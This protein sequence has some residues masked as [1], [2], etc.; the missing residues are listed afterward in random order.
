MDNHDVLLEPRTGAPL[1]PTVKLTD[2]GLAK[3]IEQDAPLLTTR[4]GSEDYAAPE[5]ILGQPYDGREADIWSLGVV[6]YALLVGFLP[7]NMRP[8]MGRKSFLSMIANAEFGFPGERVAIKRASLLKLQ[9]H[10]QRQRSS[11]N[12]STASTASVTTDSGHTGGGGGGVVPGIAHANAVTTATLL[13]A[14]T[15]DTPSTATEAA[16]EVVTTMIVPKM[17][18]VSAVSDDAKD[19]VRW[20][21]QTVGS[22]RPTAQELREHP[23]VVAGRQLA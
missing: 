5:I 14:A 15:L 21:L 11:S 18:G 4:C 9:Q 16:E 6:L 2:F 13:P 8:G 17:R 12:A 23:W 10:Q 20:L 3:V 22:K 19:L 1:R 7:F